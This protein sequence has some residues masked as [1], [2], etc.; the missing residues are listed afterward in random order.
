MNANVHVMFTP[1]TEADWQAMRGLA[2]GLTDDP[3]SIRVTAGEEPGWLVAEFTMRTQKQSSAADLVYEAIRYR[4]N[5]SDCS[6]SFPM[7]AEERAR[8]DRKLAQAIAFRCRT[9]SLPRPSK[10]I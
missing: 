5:Y 2:K 9:G 4:L 10:P 3:G 8:A 6:F 1:P 7:T